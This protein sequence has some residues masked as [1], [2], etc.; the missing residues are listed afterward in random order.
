MKQQPPDSRNCDHTIRHKVVRLREKGLS[1]QVVAK[2]V[3]VTACYASTIWKKY[4]RGGLEA[5]KPGRR[6]RRHGDQRILTADQET[7]VLKM[8]LDKTP[9]QLGFPVQLWSRDIVRQVIRKLYNQ[10]LPRRTMGDYFKRWGLVQQLQV[11]DD[12]E[13]SPPAV[14][15]W[16]S[17]TY[18]D[19][20]ARAKQEQARIY[21]GG[22]III[23]NETYRAMGYA[24][25]ADTVMI[26][27]LPVK[28]VNLFSVS[29]TRDQTLFALY[30][31]AVTSAMIQS[32]YSRLIHSADGRK[33]F[34]ILE[35][36]RQYPGRLRAQQHQDKIE[37]FCLPTD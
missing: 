29:G 9:D 5:I 37:I 30:P 12:N 7:D 36:D 34:L 1:N 23:G 2:E 11:K 10:D 18:P 25:A 14:A 35:H 15:Q 32:F 6:G 33:V 31:W 24:P 28:Q 4:Q 22:V 3:G 27:R 21:R 17:S 16:F 26:Q 19:I 13:K 8:L 20:L